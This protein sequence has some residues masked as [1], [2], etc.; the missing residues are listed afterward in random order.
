[1]PIAWMFMAY[2][3]IR[4]NNHFVTCAGSVCRLLGYRG[5]VFVVL[6][7]KSENKKVYKCAYMQ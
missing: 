4:L 3:F 1:M 2:L 5:D 6:F 7:L